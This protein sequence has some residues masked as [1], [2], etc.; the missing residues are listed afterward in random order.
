MSDTVTN[1]HTIHE[2]DQTAQHI[3]D[4]ARE[5][6]LYHGT[7][8]REDMPAEMAQSLV[9]QFQEMRA[10]WHGLMPDDAC[11]CGEGV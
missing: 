4:L 10:A 7:L 11:E 5:V 3:V 6:A 8:I 1:L 2:T 9:W